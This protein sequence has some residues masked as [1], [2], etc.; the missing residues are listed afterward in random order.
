MEYKN[1]DKNGNIIERSFGVGKEGAPKNPEVVVHTMPKR[2]LSINADAKKARNTGLFILILGLIIVLGASGAAYYFFI[3]KKIPL[4]NKNE[5]QPVAP[6]STTTPQTTTTAST[7]PESTP[8]KTA[9][10]TASTTPEVITVEIKPST[11]TPENTATTTEEV[12]VMEKVLDSDSDGLTDAEEALLGINVNE[13]DTD[14]DTY[15]DSIELR[16]L[17]NPGG[18]GPL[19]NNPNISTYKNPVYNYSLLYPKDWEVEAMDDNKTVIFKTN[20]DQHISVN[21]V[22]ITENQSIEDWYKEN[23]KVDNINE[24]QLI[25]QKGWKGIKSDDGL[26]YYLTDP[27][28]KNIYIVSY[29]LGLSNKLNYPNIFYAMVNSM[30]K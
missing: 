27:S 30:L 2:Y 16:G 29:S 13:A 10:T 3:F 25:S 26:T 8:E 18:G 7:T 21:T 22:P 23:F 5:N 17:Y 20:T 14:K 12:V 1:I 9:T 24:S 19:E 6:V 28:N 11:T 4:F 15:I